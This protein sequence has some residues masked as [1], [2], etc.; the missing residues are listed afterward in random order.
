MNLE[1]FPVSYLSLLPL[2]TRESLLWR[3][4][5]ADICKLEGTKFVEGFQDMTAY[6]KLSC[7]E[8]GGIA[9]GDIDITRY[10]EEWDEAV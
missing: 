4:P 7:E 8:F 1:G 6:W 10:V 3:L 2:K 9:P 5:I